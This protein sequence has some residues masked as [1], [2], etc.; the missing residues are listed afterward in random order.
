MS[1]PDGHGSPIL[2]IPSTFDS[3]QI[4]EGQSYTL[5]AVEVK[6]TTITCNWFFVV[7]VIRNYEIEVAYDPLHKFTFSA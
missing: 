7:E 5:T 6:T 2:H 3:L 1:E 4:R